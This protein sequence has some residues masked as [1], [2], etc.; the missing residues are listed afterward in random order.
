VDGLP[1]FDDGG[2][3]VHD[4]T[5]EIK[6]KSAQRHAGRVKGKCGGASGGGDSCLR[7]RARKRPAG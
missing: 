7:R 3:G 4:E 2:F 1:G 6:D 5:V